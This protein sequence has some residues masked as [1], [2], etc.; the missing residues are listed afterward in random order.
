MK[1][2]NDDLQST[3]PDEMDGI[4]NLIRES[5]DQLQVLSKEIK[6]FIDELDR[7]SK[8]FDQKNKLKKIKEGFQKEV[9][10]HKT[11]LEGL[12]TWLYDNRRESIASSRKKSVV[13][14]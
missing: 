7:Q 1:N 3:E 9:Q 14:K 4:Q 11:I 8:G 2:L 5:K 10:R 6:I 12:I 13:K